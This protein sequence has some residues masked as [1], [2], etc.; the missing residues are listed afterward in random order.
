MRRYTEPCQSYLLGKRVG[1]Y[2]IWP[3]YIGSSIYN[4]QS[5]WNGMCDGA[6][7]PIWTFGVRG[8]LAG[9]KIRRLWFDSTR[10]HV[11]GCS[12]CFPPLVPRVDG[13]GFLIMHQPTF[14]AVSLLKGGQKEPNMEG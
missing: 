10:V 6:A 4:R 8:V 3:A 13:W 12:V 9:L 11:K 1:V 2:G 14:G 5:P 7:F